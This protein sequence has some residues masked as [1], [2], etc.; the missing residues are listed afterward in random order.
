MEL[1]K[2]NIQMFG[3][4]NFAKMTQGISKDGID[5]IYESIHSYL[6]NA[7]KTALENYHNFFTSLDTYW[8]GADREVFK[9]NLGNAVKKVEA[10]WEECDGLIKQEFDDI[11]A[12]WETFEANNVK[13][14]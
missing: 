12:N 1:I 3:D 5:A 2:L 10:K 14:R 9:T 13:A 4:G 8:E 6:D 7:G 11:K